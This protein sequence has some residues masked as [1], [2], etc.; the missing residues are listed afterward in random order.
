MAHWS[1]RVRENGSWLDRIERRERE[2]AEGRR[3]PQARREVEPRIAHHPSV[4]SPAMPLRQAV[5]THTATGTRVTILP[6]PGTPSPRPKAGRFRAAGRRRRPAIGKNP[7]RKKRDVVPVSPRDLDEMFAA[8]HEGRKA[9]TAV[10]RCRNIALLA[11]L[12]CGFSARRL[13]RMQMHEL[14]ELRL[15]LPA[16]YALI[17]WLRR[18]TRL[19]GALWTSFL[20]LSADAKPLDTRGFYKLVERCFKR[21]WS[22]RPVPISALRLSD[23]W[24][25]LPRVPMP[26]DGWKVQRPGRLRVRI[27]RPTVDR[28]PR[29]LAALW[30]A[31]RA[32]GLPDARPLTHSGAS[33][34]LARHHQ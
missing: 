18:R 12:L 32:N 3:T 5:V 26:T 14:A 13:A 34:L 2:R 1:D 8:M 17:A 11:M 24:A 20:F 4:P 7:P 31:R 9:R 29:A 21:A 28:D 22:A 27:P 19:A 15:P 25:H 6:A 30:R 33:Q 16:W 10:A 23:P